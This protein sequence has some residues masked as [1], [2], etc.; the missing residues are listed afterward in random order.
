MSRKNLIKQSLFATL[1]LCI[2][3]RNMSTKTYYKILGKILEIS[4]I[5]DKEY[6]E[7]GE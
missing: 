1:G 7:K 2:G 3:D 5:I 6:L 4:N